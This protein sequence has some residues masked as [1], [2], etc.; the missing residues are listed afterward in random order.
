MWVVDWNSLRGGFE[1][2]LSWIEYTDDDDNND[3]NNNDDN[4]D[5]NNNNKDRI[6]L[7]VIYKVFSKHFSSF[8]DLWSDVYSG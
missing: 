8:L 2:L 1:S 4:N 5:N 3:N 7:G 6:K